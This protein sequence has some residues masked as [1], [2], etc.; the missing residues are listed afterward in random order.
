MEMNKQ[1]PILVAW[2]SKSLASSLSLSGIVF[3]NSF[4]GV[5]VSRP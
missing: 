2:R 4:E 1:V 5:D 3:S